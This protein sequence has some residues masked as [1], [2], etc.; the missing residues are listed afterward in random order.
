MRLATKPLLA[1]F[2]FL[3]ALALLRLIVAPHV[4]LGV[5]EAHY[6]L[7]GHF[8]DLSYFDHPPLVGWSEY[9]FTSMF[10]FNE[11]GARVPAIFIGIIASFNIYRLLLHVTHNDRL[12]LFGVVALNSVFMFNALFLMLMPETLLFLLAIP[13]IFT[14][15]EVER[16]NRLKDWLFLGLL[17]G[18]AGLAKYTAIL[19][20]VAVIVYLA[21]KR[22]L[23]LILQPGI[24]VALLIALAMIAPVII[25]NMQHEWISFAFQANHVTGNDAISLKAFTQSIGAQF[26]AYSPLLFP[27][28]FFGLYHALKSRNDALFLSGIVAAV[29]WLFFT[30][31][32]LYNR[33]LPHWSGLFYYLMIPVGAVYMYDKAKG[34]KRYIKAAVTISLLISLALYFELLFK[35]NPFP[36]Y[37]SLHRDIYGFDTI[38]KAANAHLE[39]GEA[40]AVTNWSLAS[41][42]LYYNL[43]YESEL[44]LIDKRNDQFDIWLKGDPIGK[45][46]LFISTHDFKAKVAKKM[47]CEAIVPR[48]S[49][50]IVLGGNRVNTATFTLCQNFGGMR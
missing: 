8:L 35:F 26:G 40:L 3:S 49:I 12:A 15:I 1:L 30:Y 31:A 29:I 33:A 37:R 27:V 50:D 36:D 48:G 14:V 32:S 16:Y 39:Q 5:D 17:L 24:I 18:L 13:I 25:W 46:L 42:A 21:F 34:Y 45:D 47:T 41:R 28:A 9:L 19:F 23:R 6:V 43:P 7:Y 11:F 2:Y 22:H 38:M 4:G 44:F 10:G 20:V